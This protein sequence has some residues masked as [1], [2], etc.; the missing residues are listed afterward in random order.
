MEK[1]L[2]RRRPPRWLV[3]STLL[4]VG[5]VSALIAAEC[6]YRVW[7]SIANA[8]TRAAFENIDRPPPLEPGTE[9]TLAQVA[10]RAKHPRIIYELIPNLRGV[11]FQGA[12]LETNS[13]GFRGPECPGEKQRRSLRIVGLGDSVQFGWAVPEPECMFRRLEKRLREYFPDFQ[14]DVI[15]TAVPGYNTAMEVATLEQKCLRLQPDA[16]VIDYVGNDTDLPSLIWRD[17]DYWTLT[18]S[19]LWERIRLAWSGEQDPWRTR[20]FDD[21][22]QTVAGDR[23]ENDPDRVPA[24]YRDMVGREGWRSAMYHL[25][26]LSK[27]NGFAVFVTAHWDVNDMVENTCRELGLPLIRSYHR[28]VGYLQERGIKEYWGSELTRS[29]DDPHPS[30]KNHE[31]QA[32]VVFDFLESNGL[33]ALWAKAK[34]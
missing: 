15:N 11:V 19:F 25:V 27:Q 26:E 24:A 28:L 10:R 8:R 14:V 9:A 12:P 34:R 6:A 5:V 2:R 30:S 23:F 22:P 33:L 7:L 3:R 21:A 20:A 4:L 17:R 16:V 29:K 31:I 13:D 18:H 1:S 32:E